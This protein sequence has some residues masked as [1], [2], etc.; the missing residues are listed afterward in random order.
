MINSQIYLGFLQIQSINSKTFGEYNIS[1]LRDARILEDKLKALGYK[2]DKDGTFKYCRQLLDNNLLVRSSMALTDETFENSPAWL[3]DMFNRYPDNITK[4][5]LVNL[6]K[7][8]NKKGKYKK[9]SVDLTQMV[10]DKRGR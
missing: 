5:Y 2:S 8:F 6:T 3:K 1:V 10:R 7:T 4:K 9:P